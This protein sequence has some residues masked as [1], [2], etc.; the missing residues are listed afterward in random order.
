MMDFKK[1]GAWI[2]FCVVAAAVAI[3]ATGALDKSFGLQ[4]KVA[5]F[6]K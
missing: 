1:L 3:V 6:G 5:K 2:V 4:Q